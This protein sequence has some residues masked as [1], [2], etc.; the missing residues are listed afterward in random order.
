[1]KNIT[2]DKRQDTTTRILF[3]K[4]LVDLADV[5]SCYDKVYHYQVIISYLRVYSL[6]ID[7]DSIK[8]RL[9]YLLGS[10]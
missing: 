2:K 5:L 8:G 4:V 10:L 7:N 1:M 6:F 3:D 9:L